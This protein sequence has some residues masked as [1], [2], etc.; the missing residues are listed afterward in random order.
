MGA[1][2]GAIEK[3]RPCSCTAKGRHGC[4]GFPL[5]V[6][7]E[8]TPQA[9]PLWGL[10]PGPGSQPHVCRFAAGAPRGGRTVATV[11]GHHA[12]VCWGAR[13]PHGF[14]HGYKR[15][16]AGSSVPSIAPPQPDICTPAGT[17]SCLW[18]CHVG[19]QKP[20]RKEETFSSG[21]GP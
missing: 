13:A 6:Q 19:A 15:K 9:G 21:S 7:M 20:V 18:S 4:V 10:P 5:M 14:T 3:T 16:S 12:I 17:L 2:P 11:P 8:E 1:A